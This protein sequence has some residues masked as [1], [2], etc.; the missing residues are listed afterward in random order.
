MQLQKAIIGKK[1]GMTQIFDESGK[2]I[3]VTVIAAGPCTVTQ[4]KTAE[5]DGYDAVQLGYEDVKESKLTKPELGHL[6][7]AEVGNKKFLKEFRLE[8]AADMNVGDEVKADVFAEGD[9]VDVTGISKGHGYQG[10]IKRWGAQRTPT[11]HGGGPVHRHAGSMGSCSDPS[12]IFKG[13]IG[14]GQMGVE[15]V[16]IQNLDVVKVDA[17]LNMIV[18]R[19]AIP[20]PKGGLVCIKNTVKNN[21]VKQGATAVSLNP[22]KASA[23]VNPQKASA[24]TR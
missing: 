20:G 9:K 14:A 11:T 22:Q 13:K 8:K 24:R 19:G 3:P 18:V 21:R 23:R 17:E 1:V 6:K 10:V 15:Q 7:K 4:K 5:K 16:T 2:V 12:R